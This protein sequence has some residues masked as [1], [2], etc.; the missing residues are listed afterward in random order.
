MMKGRNQ[1]TKVPR[2]YINFD[3]TYLSGTILLNA[4]AL[5][6]GLAFDY[7]LMNCNSTLGISRGHSTITDSYENY[8][9]DSVVME[10]LPTIGPADTYAGTQM[11]AA[12]ID[13]AEDMFFIINT[14]TVTTA[15]NLVQRVAKPFVWNAWERVSWNVPLTRRRKT[16]AVNTT[17][18]ETILE[19]ERDCQ[20]L[21]VV[22]QGGPTSGTP[23]LGTFRF[24]YKLRLNGLASSPGT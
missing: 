8:I 2:P 1:I 6:S 4:S 24:V 11:S 20:G 19:M 3:G 9:Y 18:T 23:I 10:W 12:Y 15:K 17:I 13:N 16:F 22:I 7:H 14:A 5:A 21:V